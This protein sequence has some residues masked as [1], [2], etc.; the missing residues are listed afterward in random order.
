[1]KSLACRA[2]QRA[3]GLVIKNMINGAQSIKQPTPFE[4]SSWHQG[5]EIEPCTVFHTRCGV[6]LR[7]SSLCPPPTHSHTLSLKNKI[8]NPFK[9][10]TCMWIRNFIIMKQLNLN[11]NFSMTTPKVSSFKLL[12][13]S[14]MVK[15]DV[16][17]LKPPFENNLC[18]VSVSQTAYISHVTLYAKPCDIPH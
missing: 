7:L 1:M 16:V 5:S 3:L 10:K 4:L 12:K 17:K 18:L 8:I 14:V 11:E 6:S 2:R 15:W 9:K 13:T